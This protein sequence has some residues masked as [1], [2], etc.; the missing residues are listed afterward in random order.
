MECKKCQFFMVNMDNLLPKE[1]CKSFNHFTIAE[2]RLEGYADKWGCKEGLK[3]F[4][5]RIKSAKMDE[6]EIRDLDS[7]R[8]IAG[9]G[10]LSA[11]S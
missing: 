9:L 10:A 2:G 6:L 4:L 8:D 7:R 5:I 11:G 1:A 3:N